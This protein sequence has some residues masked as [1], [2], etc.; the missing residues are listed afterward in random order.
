MT[1]TVLPIRPVPVE[2]VDAFDDFWVLYPRRISKKQ[3]H[4]Y[5]RAIDPKNHVKIL[6]AIAAWRVHWE[7]TGV[8][9]QWIPYPSTWLIGERW[10]DEIPSAN[11][12]SAHVRCDLPQGARTEMPEHVRALLA[13]LRKR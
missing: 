10:E 12:S 4:K 3:T 6:T 5:F 9:M 8:E 11:H 13:K 7:Q 1:A 2:A